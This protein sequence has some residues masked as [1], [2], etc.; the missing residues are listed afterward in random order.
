MAELFCFDGGIVLFRWWNCLVSM[1]ELFSFDGGIVLFSMEELYRRTN[2]IAP[3]F[4][5]SHLLSIYNSRE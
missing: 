2:K 3:T 5:H 1:E 4:Y